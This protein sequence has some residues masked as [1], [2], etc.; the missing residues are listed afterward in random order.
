MGIDGVGSNGRSTPTRSTEPTTRPARVEATPAAAMRTA[1]ETSRFETR[2]AFTLDIEPPRPAAT[3]AAER[4][5]AATEVYE[6]ARE[7][8]SRLNGE[9]ERALTSEPALRDSA[10]AERFCEAF[11]EAHADTYAKEAEAA[12]ALA[13]SL[14]A[15]APELRADGRRLQAAENMANVELGLKALAGSSEYRQIAELTRLYGQGAD[16]VFTRDELGPIA[17]RAA[18]TGLRE[19]LSAGRSPQDALRTAGGFLGAA[20]FASRTP[21]LSAI[22][23]A[24]GAGADLSDFMRTGDPAS[25]GAAGFGALGTAAAV[26]AMVASGPIAVGAGVVGAAALGGKFITRRIAGDNAYHAAVDGPLAAALSV[27]PVELETLRSQDARIL[28]DAGLTTS[29]I[30]SAI[31]K[32]TLTRAAELAWGGRLMTGDY[33]DAVTEEAYQARMA[34][35]QEEEP[36]QPYG[37]YDSLAMEQLRAERRAQ[38]TG[39]ALLREDLRAQGLID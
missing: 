6:A 20:G 29:E 38:G 25:L 4:V 12:R 3:A 30:R 35:L 18:L 10:A 37:Y 34:K 11:R 7:E 33:A 32:G 27:S 2:P 16:P 5:S 8:V 14:R 19:D 39:E 21:A 26:T 22:G 17:E 23:N 28:Y 9:L 24:I 1:R 36:G 31:D 13:E 15:A